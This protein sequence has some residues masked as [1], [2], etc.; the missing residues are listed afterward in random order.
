MFSIGN[1][2]LAGHFE[3]DEVTGRSASVAKAIAHEVVAR[4]REEA[5]SRFEWYRS[6]RVALRRTRDDAELRGGTGFAELV[7]T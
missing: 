2:F 6:S 5:H 7:D 1:A 4:L 3:E